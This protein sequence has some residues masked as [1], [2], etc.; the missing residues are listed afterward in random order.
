M[1]LRAVFLDVGNTLVRERPSR[2]E[3][4]A[5]CARDQ[6]LA[7]TTERM[8]DLMRKA[9]R[10][11]PREIN[12][13]WRYTERWFEAYIE[14]IFTVELGLPPERLPQLSRALFARFSDPATFELFPGAL[15]LCERARARGLV[16]GLVSNWSQR[17]PGLVERLGL[18]ARIDFVICSAIERAEKPDLE[19][20]RMALERAGVSADEALHAG[21]DLDKDFHGA[22]RAGLRA[23]LVDHARARTDKAPRVHDLRELDEWVERLCA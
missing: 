22:Q 23:V 14:R 12:G 1:S 3:I 17:L 5:E 16:V 9:H 8:T 19:I 15:E 18:A 2:F 20:F 6:G 11:L 21:D 10:E 13:A 4:Y 7:V